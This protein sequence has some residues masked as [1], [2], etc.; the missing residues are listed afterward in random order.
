LF[1]IGKIYETQGPQQEDVF[2]KYYNDAMAADAGFAPVYYDL[3]T[4]FYNRDVTKSKSYLDKYIANSDPDPK[5]CY[6]YASILYASAAFQQSISKSE[7]CIKSAGAKPYPNLYGLEAYAYDKMGDSINAKKFFEA[8][9]ANQDPEKIGP[10]DYST[11]AKT[12]LKLQGDDSIAGVNIDKAINLDSLESDKIND[13]R[14]MIN[15]YNSKKNYLGAG[16]WYV[17]IIGLKRNP[18]NNDYQTAGFNY[19]VGGDF[20]TAAKL[21]D[22]TT[23]K[24]P[25]DVYSWYMLGRSYYGID[26]S[27]SQGL[28]NTAF[29]K[30][31]D[32]GDTVNYKAQIM[33]SYK[34]FIGYYY[35]I[36]HDKAT[37]LDM[38]NK[39][40]LV[41]PTDADIINYKEL[42]SKANSQK[43]SSLAGEKKTK[44]AR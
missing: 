18:T 26:T 5:N 27:M 41:D 43:S 39:A 23:Q 2:M 44:K 37:A 35:N 11:Y 24:F 36:K 34:Y 30:V 3:Y 14:V 12:L 6:Y 25:K 19:Y 7:E 33:G 13:A 42:L 1:K 38:C 22:G 15:Y 8:Y 40:L 31:I 16:N 10:T 28:A 20:V 32:L 21:F 4:Y 17:K 9:F 29:Q